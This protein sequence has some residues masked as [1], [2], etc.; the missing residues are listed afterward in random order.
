MVQCSSN[1]QRRRQREI[2]WTENTDGLQS[3]GYKKTGHNWAQHTGQHRQ[4]ETV[5]LPKEAMIILRLEQESIEIH[6]SNSPITCKNLQ[7]SVLWSINYLAKIWSL[8]RAECRN[9]LTKCISLCKL[10]VP[11]Y[12]KRW[13]Y[14]RK[15]KIRTKFDIIIYTIKADIFTCRRV[16][17]INYHN[18][19]FQFF[20]PWNIL[21]I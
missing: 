6:Y 11:I 17:R 4:R 7:D 16:Y 2:P 18:A 1:W 3:M 21:S 5:L 10:D 20:T 13:D 8:Y 14:M 12:R 9:R 19:C 15:F